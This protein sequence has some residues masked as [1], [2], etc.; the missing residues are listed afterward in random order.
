MKI[1]AGRYYKTR[2]GRTVGPITRGPITDAA[3]YWQSDGDLNGFQSAWF[4]DGSFWPE[5][6]PNKCDEISR[7]DLISPA[8]DTTPSPVRTVTTTRQEIVPGVYGQIRV[9]DE[10]CEKGHVCLGS[11]KV[12]YHWTA[13]ELT[14]AI[15][16]LTEIRATL[17]A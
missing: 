15:Q 5:G 11:N 8:S 10:P 13:D 14:A 17:T 7:L 1:E 9:Y 6:H 3:R 12:A 4:E 2:D 16:T